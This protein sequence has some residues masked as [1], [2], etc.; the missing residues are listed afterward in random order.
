VLREDGTFGD[1]FFEKW[2]AECMAEKAHPK[3]P[4][5]MLKNCDP[6]KLEAI[7]SQ[8]STPDADFKTK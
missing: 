4:D 1:S 2:V 6:A 5:Q 8:F 3:S 7:L